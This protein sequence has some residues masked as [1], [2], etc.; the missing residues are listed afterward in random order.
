MTKQEEMEYRENLP[1][2]AMGD[3]SALFSH[4]EEEEKLDEDEIG[5]IV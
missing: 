1:Y 4:S 5:V 3:Y 2:D